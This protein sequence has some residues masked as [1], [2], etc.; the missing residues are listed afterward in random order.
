MQLKMRLHLFQESDK[1]KG[2]SFPEDIQKS[3][4]T[5][6]ILHGFE[7]AAKNSMH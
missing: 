6:K 3:K 4:K 2:I 1:K 7:C 5:P